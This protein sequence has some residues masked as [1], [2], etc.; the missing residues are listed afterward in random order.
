MGALDALAAGLAVV[1]ALLFA[2]ASV[3]QRGAAADVPDE[4][5]GGRRLV[6]RLI[7]SPRW[8]VGAGGDTVA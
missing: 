1:A 8:W 4:D 3:A 2:V 7:R 5:A 6:A